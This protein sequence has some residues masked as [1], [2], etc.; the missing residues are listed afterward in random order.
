MNRYGFLSVTQVAEELG[1]ARWFVY[2]LL[3][4]RKLAFHMIGG[5]R[6]V[7]PP[8]LDAYIERCRVAALGEGKSKAQPA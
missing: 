7:S 3:D 5:H 8:D 4:E 2:K 6:V 1:R